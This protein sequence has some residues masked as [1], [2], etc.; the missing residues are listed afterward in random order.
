MRIGLITP[1]DTVGSAS[2]NDLIQ[3]ATQAEQDGFDSFWFVQLPHSG[4]DVLTAISLAGLQTNRIEL[5]TGVVPTYPRHP[6]VMAQQALTTQVATGGRLTLGL[7]LSHKPV[8]EDVMGL[9]YASPARHMREYLSV[10]R[11]LVEQGK[12][13]FAGEVFNVKGQLRVAESS[14]FPILIAALAPL[15]LRIAGELADGTV[16][17]MG[18]LKAIEEHIVPRINAA[19]E[20]AGRPQP[21][22]CVALPVAVTNDPV[23]AREHVAKTLQ[24]YGQLANYR[25]LLDVEDAEG[26]ADVAVVGN[27]AQV[28]RQ[29]RAFADAGTTDFIASIFPVGEDASVSVSRTTI[30]LK[31][32]VGK[33]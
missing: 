6:L 12:V 16:T 26:P 23:D 22:V 32:L 25:R 28:E 9:S 4:C 3:Q 8:I 11:P 20:V 7:G 1:P 27:E 17:W 15:M 29:L 21:R 24:R 14:P 13:D 18:G 19:A 10:L 2:L 5:G 30:L 33:I 31:E